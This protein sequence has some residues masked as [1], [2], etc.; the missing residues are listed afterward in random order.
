MQPCNI[1]YLCDLSYRV[2]DPE[3]ASR[4]ARHHRILRM[5][6]AY[7]IA[8]AVFLLPHHI[9]WLIKDFDDGEKKLHF[10]DAQNVLYIFTY[11]ITIVN[12]ILFFVYNPEFKRHFWHYLKC[13]CITKKELFSVENLSESFSEE[14]DPR[15]RKFRE[16]PK[17]D[18]KYYPEPA[19]NNFASTPTM[20]RA[21]IDSIP[22]DHD[23][24]LGLVEASMF[25][26]AVGR[27]RGAEKQR[28]S[29][30]SASPPASEDAT[31]EYNDA[32]RGS[33]DQGSE[34]L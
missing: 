23:S 12:P 34:M 11:S 2:L 32:P 22:R 33:F 27:F 30:P 25:P 7:V 31:F 1:L 3:R 17:Y 28:E 4:R 18:K 15:P 14:S 8:F 29:S 24:G 6:V 26:S 10:T 5:M 19:E 21:E 9:M 13:Q 20:L 16:P